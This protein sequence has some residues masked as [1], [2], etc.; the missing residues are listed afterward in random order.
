[1]PPP[2][3][4]VL[5]V[6]GAS[7]GIGRAAA[8]QAAARGDH[9][10][11]AA[12]DERTLKETAIECDAAG[13]ASTLVVP[14]DVGDDEAV[15]ACVRQVLDRHGRLDGVAHC[16]GVVA[17]GRIEDVPPEVFE[18][19][20]R[21]NLLGSVNLARHV[22]PVLRD[23]G[24]G[25]LVLVGSIVGHLGVPGMSPYV[26]SKWGVR[27]L[28]RQL[29]LENRDAGDVSVSLVSPGGVLTPIYEQAANYSGWAGRPP[30]PVDSPEKVA[31]VVLDRIDHPRKRTQVGL[32]N[33]V[34]RFGF[35]FM[36]GVYDV[37]VGPLF[38]LAANDLT[39]PLSPVVGNVLRSVPE[40]NKVLGDQVGA[41]V[42]VSRNVVARIRQLAGSAR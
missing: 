39:Q 40:G 7:S 25:G 33:D 14:V 32:A 11:L 22:V 18:G 27:A 13:A 23:Q 35:T 4:R 2:S 17:Y 28:A 9:L 29:Q 8:R 21:T 6:T 1:M 36:P 26:I 30:P 15:A 41:L 10:V 20:L 12:R 24:R 3:P 5:L 19:V 42:G 16:A 34:M 37:L 31:R 38:R